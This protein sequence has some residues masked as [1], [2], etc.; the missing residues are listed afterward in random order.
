MRP[1]PVSKRQGALMQIQT[2]QTHRLF[3]L[4][5]SVLTVVAVAAA[6]TMFAAM[7]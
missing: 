2:F 7:G 6:W 5:W 1:W 4:L 3:W